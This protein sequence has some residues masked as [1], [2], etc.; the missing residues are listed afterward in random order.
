MID[1]PLGEHREVVLDR[2]VL[3]HLGV[4]GRADHD[5]CPGGEQVAV[6]RSSL[7]PAA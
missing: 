6:S 2:G 4:H 1:A 3:P 7:I 5:R